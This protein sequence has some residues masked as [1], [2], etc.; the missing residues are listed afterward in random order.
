MPERTPLNIWAGFL[1]HEKLKDLDE[2]YLLSILGLCEELVERNPEPKP[3]RS[4]KDRIEC[5]KLVVNTA[6]DLGIDLPAMKRKN[7]V[8]MGRGLLD[9]WMEEYAKRFGSNYG[10]NAWAELK[11]RG[12]STKLSKE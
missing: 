5:R 10:T 9:V 1:A 6:M 7:K 4:Y 3:F 12:V 11:R 2:P 8:A